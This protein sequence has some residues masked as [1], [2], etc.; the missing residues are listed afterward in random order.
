MNVINSPH[1]LISIITLRNRG[2]SIAAGNGSADAYC[3]SSTGAMIYSRQQTTGDGVRTLQLTDVSET[4]W[5]LQR[6]AGMP[7]AVEWNDSAEE[8]HLL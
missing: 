1:V 5:W 3:A 6:P 7:A 4:E 2:E 8:C